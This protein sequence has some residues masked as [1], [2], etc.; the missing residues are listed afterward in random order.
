MALDVATQV[1]N[2]QVINPGYKK[3]Q[4]AALPQAAVSGL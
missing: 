4:D 1:S 2:P 3:P